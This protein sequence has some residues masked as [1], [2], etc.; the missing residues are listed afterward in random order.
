MGFI[1]PNSQVSY[2]FLLL[3]IQG[4]RLSREINFPSTL[5]NQESTA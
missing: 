5:G 3:I 2:I 1:N 4:F